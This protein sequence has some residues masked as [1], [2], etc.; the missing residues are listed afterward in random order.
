MNY[1][2]NETFSQTDG[3][4]PKKKPGLWAPA[5]E[6]HPHPSLPHQRG[7]CE[8]IELVLFHVIPAKAGIQCFQGFTN[9]LDPG[10]HRGDG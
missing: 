4:W 10:F 6:N 9:L 8:K 5:L 1:T 7:R 2:R 3:F